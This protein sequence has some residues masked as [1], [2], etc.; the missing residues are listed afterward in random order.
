[1][2]NKH[3]RKRVLGLIFLG[4]VKMGTSNVNALKAIEIETRTETLVNLVNYPVLGPTVSAT[5]G[6]TPL[7]EGE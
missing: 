4:T 6:R 3:K 2:F 7:K 1:L 5:E